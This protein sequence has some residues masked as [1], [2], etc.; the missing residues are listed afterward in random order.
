MKKY[1]SKI[2]LFGE[3]SVIKGSQALAMPLPNFFG[4]WS[5]TKENT[6]QVQM[7][8][9]DFSDYLLQLK[10]DKT[11]LCDLDIEGLKHELG[12]GLFFESNIPTGY[13]VGSSG[14]LC[15]AIYD[16]FCLDKLSKTEGDFLPLKKIF[17][18]LESYFHGSSSGTDPLICYLEKTLLLESKDIIKAVDIAPQKNYQLFLLDTKIRR[19]T[20]PFVNIFLEKCT[21]ENY[22]ARIQSELN[23]AVDEAIAAFL[24]QSEKL[25]FEKI[26]EIGHFQFKYFQE[27]I[28]DD[29]RSIW[30][31]ALASD[32]FKIKL[33]GAGGGGFILGMTYDFEKTKN[34]LQQFTLIPISI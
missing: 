10:N 13:G 5:K 1:T 14:A 31:D 27:M 15:A 25:L 4:S 34:H 29:F 26:H 30:L 3:H 20:E 23:P 19:A 24:S 9:V 12:R 8:L 17:A 7:N 11:L 6:K 18:Q 21:D 2:L 28:L 33:C 22:F 32:F 16:T